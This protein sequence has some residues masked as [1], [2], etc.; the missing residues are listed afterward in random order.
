MDATLWRRNVESLSIYY[1]NS[2]KTQMSIFLHHLALLYLMFLLLMTTLMKVWSMQHHPYV[3]PINTDATP[4]SGMDDA[5][6]RVE[7]EDAL[8][9]L[10]TPPDSSDTPQ[11]RVVES[12][13]LI[14]GKLKSKACLLADF[15]KYG[16]YSG[17][18]NRLC[19]VQD[20]GQ[21]IQN[22]SVTA[23]TPEF[24]LPPKDNLEVLLISDP[25]TTIL[26]VE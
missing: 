10:S 21:H 12:Q 4:N 3:G 22:K 18:T 7:V 25:I 8:G 16:K 26:S 14:N 23:N 17:S 20:I 2:L 1:G 13:I 5:E 19:C 24:L 15:A 9:E 11:H 6:V